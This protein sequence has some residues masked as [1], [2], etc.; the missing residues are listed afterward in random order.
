MKDIYVVLLIWGIF[1]IV[2][3]KPSKPAECTAPHQT[4]VP[5]SFDDIKR[6]YEIYAIGVAA[7]SFQHIKVT[8]I[9]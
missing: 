9:S 2:S 8:Q 7:N 4:A 3:F 5:L 6:L 1:D